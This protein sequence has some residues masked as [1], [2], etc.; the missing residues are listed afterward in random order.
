MNRLHVLLVAAKI[1]QGDTVG[2]GYLSALGIAPEVLPA[3]RHEAEKCSQCAPKAYLQPCGCFLLM[4]ELAAA[5][6]RE[7]IERP[8]GEVK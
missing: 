6:E 7:L 5:V 3:A 1:A 4:R 8:R 2:T